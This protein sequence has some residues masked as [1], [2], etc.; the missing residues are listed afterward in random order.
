VSHLK[1]PCDGTQSLHYLPVFDQAY[2][3]FSR[4]LFIYLTPEPFYFLKRKTHF[5]HFP[6]IAFDDF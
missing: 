5:R 4:I 6:P 2:N 3:T 1:Q